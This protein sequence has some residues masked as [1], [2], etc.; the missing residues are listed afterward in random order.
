[1]DLFPAIDL[2]DNQVVRL[3]QGDYDQQKTYASDPVAQA[4]AFADAGAKWLHMVDL[5]GARVGQMSHLEVVGRVCQETSLKVQ[6]GGGVRTQGAIDRLL[7]VG[8]TRVILGTA[9]LENWAWFEKLVH[10]QAYH[11]R[12]VLGLDARKGSLAISGWERQLDTTALEV[13]RRVTD[14]PLAAIVFT[15]I[16]TDGTMQGPNVPS[17]QEIAACTRVPVIASGGIGNLDHLRA[18][19]GLELAGV[20]VGRAIYEKVFGVEEAIATLGCDG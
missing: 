2:R 17:T 18:L 3:H 8:V 10:D 20:I 15:D 14:W 7:A 4:Q 19:R 6:F 1:M 9:A 12:V 13:A 16:A 5:D 11:Q